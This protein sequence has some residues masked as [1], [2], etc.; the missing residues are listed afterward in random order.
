M[1]GAS[2]RTKTAR[3]VE[4]DRRAAQSSVAATSGRRCNV[5]ALLS[6]PEA[7]REL[8]IG[9]SKLYEWLSE[10]FIQS[11]RFPDTARR[12]IPKTEIERVIEEN[13]ALK[14]VNPDREVEAVGNSHDN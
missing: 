9:K 6:I 2:L 11:V 10:G 5:P 8:G 3:S 13:M 4:T 14:V 1:S 7:A 12:L